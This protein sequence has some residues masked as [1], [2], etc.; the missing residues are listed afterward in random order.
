[1][2][3][4]HPY[5]VGKIAQDRHQE[6]LK[7]AEAYRLY[8]QIQSGQSHRQLAFRQLWHKF[9]AAF[10]RPTTVQPTAGIRPITRPVMPQS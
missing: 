1:M 10:S 5:S 3:P 2:L 7:Q 9:Q 4:T 8:K 6:L